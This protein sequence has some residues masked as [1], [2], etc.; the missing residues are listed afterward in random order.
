M[1]T[2]ICRASMPSRCH[3]ARRRCH[4]GVQWRVLV[5]EHPHAVG[6]QTTPGLVRCTSRSRAAPRSTTEPASTS[7]GGS[8]AD[9]RSSKTTASPSPSSSCARLRSHAQV[10]GES[11]GAPEQPFQCASL[12]ARRSL[13]SE[14]SGLS[15]E[16]EPKPSP[17][18]AAALNLGVSR[19]LALANASVRN[20]ADVRRPDR[21]ALWHDLLWITRPRCR[22]QAKSSGS[23]RVVARPNLATK[24]RGVY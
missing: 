11:R 20:L 18:G 12:D 5:T 17:V 6:D 23:R 19:A 13:R 9:G 22:R 14:P 10:L 21:P 24:H 7:T 16:R 3:A 4:D 8:P 15:E 2:Q 1:T